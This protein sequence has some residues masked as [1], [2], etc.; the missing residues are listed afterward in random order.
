MRAC[1]NSTHRQLLPGCQARRKAAEKKAVAT[2]AG[3]TNLRLRHLGAESQR[4]SASDH[5][6]LDVWKQ[7]IVQTSIIRSVYGSICGL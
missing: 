6:I 2:M 5:G 3:D 1:G 7:P 4:E